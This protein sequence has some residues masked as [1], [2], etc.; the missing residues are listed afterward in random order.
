MAQYQPTVYEKIVQDFLDGKHL[1]FEDY[2]V[3]LSARGF[4]EKR[5]FD[6]YIKDMQYI[7]TLMGS[8]DFNLRKAL[9]TG[10]GIS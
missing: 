10:I 8:P 7:K 6:A 9:D 2:Q 5:Y 3:E 4:G 1:K